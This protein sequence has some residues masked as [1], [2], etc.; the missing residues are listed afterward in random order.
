[1]CWQYSLTGDHVPPVNNDTTDP[2]LVDSIEENEE[3][4]K[5]SIA[6]RIEYE[7]YERTPNL[8]KCIF[9]QCITSAAPVCVVNT[10]SHRT[11][12]AKAP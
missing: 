6:G 2:T 11:R 4:K 5:R 9:D 8:S 1:M 3:A 10:S 12:I 7:V